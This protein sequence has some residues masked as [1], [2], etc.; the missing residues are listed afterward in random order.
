MTLD[1]IPGAAKLSGD[2]VSASIVVGTIA[3]ILP[4]IAAALTIIWT[5]IRI[6]ETETV[7]RAVKRLF[8][9]GGDEQ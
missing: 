8:A 7:Q 4:S 5:G 6:F 3:Q 1:H 2:V 9:G